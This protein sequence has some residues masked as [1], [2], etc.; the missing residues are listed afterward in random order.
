MGFDDFSSNEGEFN[1]GLAIIYR[2]DGIAKLLI[3]SIIEENYEMRFK[4]L[5]CY[6]NELAG[7]EKAD[8]KFEER[9]LSYNKYHNLYNNYLLVKK[10]S[11]K[12]AINQHPRFFLQEWEL[13]LRRWGQNLGV[14]M[15]MKQDQRYAM[16]TK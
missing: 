12:I 3:Q 1:Q 10:K 4:T 13:E 11:G 8:K 2:I 6:F 14:G 9:K 15:A 16:M 7:M 5:V